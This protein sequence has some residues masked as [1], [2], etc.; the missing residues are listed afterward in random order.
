MKL[1]LHLDAAVENGNRRIRGKT[2]KILDA[3]T[4]NI[5]GKRDVVADAVQ[6]AIVAGLEH[7][8]DLSL[9]SEVGAVHCGIH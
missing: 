5:H 2:K 4:I 7:A 9:G 6:A 8:H 1:C 3:R